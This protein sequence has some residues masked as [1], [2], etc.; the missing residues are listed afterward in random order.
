ML[1]RY[2]S[3]TFILSLD[4]EEALTLIDYAVSQKDEELLFARWI[5][6]TQYQ[7]SFEEFKQGLKPIEVLEDEEIL[8]DVFK[9]INSINP[10]RGNADGNF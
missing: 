10:E 7:M 3:L 9:I 6:G 8:D 2:S 4:L 5:A 1:Q